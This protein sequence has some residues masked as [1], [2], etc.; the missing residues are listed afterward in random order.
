MTLVS[1]GFSMRTSL[2]PWVILHDDRTPV[3]SVR[4]DSHARSNGGSPGA[5]E[6]SIATEAGGKAM[7]ACGPSAVRNETNAVRSGWCP[8]RAAAAAAAPRPHAGGTGLNPGRVFGCPWLERRR[9]EPPK[10][11]GVW[12]A[13]GAA[14][15]DRPS[16]PPPSRGTS[17]RGPLVLAAFAERTFGVVHRVA[18]T[19]GIGMADDVEAHGVP[20]S[21]VRRIEGGPV[22]RRGPHGAA[23]APHHLEQSTNGAV[24][25]NEFK[26]YGAFG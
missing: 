2:S 19:D 16:R 17:P 14:A 3:R 6:E 10:R 5:G 1:S 22:V 7:E 25:I 12:R 18:G 15:E 9:R 20:G 23:D 13:G 24:R 21:S 4:R 11:R 26:D 8:P